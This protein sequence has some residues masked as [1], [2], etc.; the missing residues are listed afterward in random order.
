MRKLV[1][2]FLNAFLL[3]ACLLVFVPLLLVA[4]VGQ[5]RANQPAYSGTVHYRFD[6]EWGSAQPDEMGNGW[7]VTNNLGYRIH[8]KQGYLATVSTEMIA[9]PHTHPT[10]QSS[11]LPGIATAFFAAKTAYA[12]H[13]GNKHDASQ[14]PSSYVESIAAPKALLLT[15]HFGD[16]PDYCYTHYLI[17]SAKSWMQNLPSDRN[18]IDTSLFL[19][20]ELQSPGSQEWTP[21]TVQSKLAWGGL[22]R[23]ITQS[24]AEVAIVALEPIFPSVNVQV[25]IRRNLGTLFDNVD[26]ATMNDETRARTILSMIV[27]SATVEVVRCDTDC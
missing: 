9:C 10:P 25:M 11:L 2:R 5:T 22:L 12:G 15:S 13:S 14:I 3:M 4:S 26:F 23:P 16:E 7:S 17:A 18:M 19:A 6:W 8:L 21:F 24:A 27:K 20:G 1:R